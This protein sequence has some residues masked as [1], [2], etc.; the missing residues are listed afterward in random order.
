M[1]KPSH[2]IE[3]VEYE[4]N[5]RSYRVSSL[6]EDHY[7]SYYHPLKPLYDTIEDAKDKL[8]SLLAVTIKSVTKVYP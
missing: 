7:H 1:K 3:E 5:S 2:I 6:A 8:N 4:D